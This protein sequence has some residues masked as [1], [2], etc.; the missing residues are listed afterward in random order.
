MIEEEGSGRL[1][2]ADQ[3]RIRENID[4][5]KNVFIRYLAYLASGEEKEAFLMEKVLFTVLKAEN[6][7][8]EIVEKARKISNSGILGYFYQSGSDK[9]ARPIQTR[10]PI[11]VLERSAPVSNMPMQ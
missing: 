3:S 11:K 4:Y 8:I 9:V 1:S 7:D 6:N 5:I 10:T 2:E